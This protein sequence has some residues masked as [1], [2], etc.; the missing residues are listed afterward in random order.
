MTD[1]HLGAPERLGDASLTLGVAVASAVALGLFV[2]LP[3]S[4]GFDPP[5]GLDVLW[6]LGAVAAVLLAPVAAGLAAYVSLTALVPYG[7]RLPASVRRLHLLS[8]AVAVT[9]FVGLVLAWWSG[10]LAWLDD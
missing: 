10:S 3:G 6:A 5:V 1:P 2:L 4:S 8:L 9:F 7:G